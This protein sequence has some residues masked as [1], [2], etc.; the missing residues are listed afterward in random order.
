MFLV[1]LLLAAHSTISPA[2]RPDFSGEWQRVVDSSTA[3]PTVAATGDAAFRRGDMGTG[4]GAPL[5]IRQSAD[6]MV[7][8]YQ[9]FSTYDLQPRLHFVFRLDGSESRNTVMIGHADSQQR[10]QASWRGDTLVIVTTFAAPTGAGT[11]T[12]RQTLSLGA[13][14]TM[15]LETAR[16][17]TAPVRAT[18][19]RN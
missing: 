10:S 8:E 1:T 4:W 17:G 3:R 19:R 13:D 11:T 18:F 7:V 6:S 15:T 16:E 2:Q 9:Q 5:I 14:G 12:M